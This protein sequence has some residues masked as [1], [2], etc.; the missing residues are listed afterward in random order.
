MDTSIL[1]L[2]STERLSKYTELSSGNPDK[3]L[4]LYLFN[5]KVSSS[6]FEVIGGFEVA[7]RNSI[8]LTLKPP[9]SAD[10]WYDHVP[11]PWLRHEQNALNNAKR[12]IRARHKQPTP[13]RIVA[14]LTLGFWCE[15]AASPY[16]DSLWIP[17]LYKAFPYKRLGR[18]EAYERLNG[19]RLLRNRIA[20]HECIL[21]MNLP[22]EHDK[23]I[24][25]VGWICPH[26]RSWIEGYSSFPYDGSQ[27]IAESNVPFPP[28]PHEARTVDAECA[29]I[30]QA[31]LIP[32]S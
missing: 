20:H 15:L 6:L 25:A 17:H 14:E 21:H 7:L 10:D 23:I 32:L 1:R 12:Q 22:A 31:G 11:F 19:I 29:S 16:R 24:E 8:H 9:F 5:L 27:T 13:G 3:A 26:T 2:L 4:D 30:P 28:H 18:K